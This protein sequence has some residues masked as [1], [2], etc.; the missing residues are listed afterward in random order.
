[1]YVWE[2]LTLIKP[3]HLSGR[4]HNAGNAN[5]T[6]KEDLEKKAVTKPVYLEFKKSYFL[7]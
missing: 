5:L 2:L 3:H 6:P 1:M 7:D 4:Q